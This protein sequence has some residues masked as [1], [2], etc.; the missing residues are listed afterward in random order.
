MLK[1]RF[2]RAENGETID[3][4]KPDYSHIKDSP[5]LNPTSSMSNK[6]E[7][8]SETTQ[9]KILRELKEASKPDDK[10]PNNVI[11][12]LGKKNSPS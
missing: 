4:G 5:P 1:P 3:N 7:P 2:E 6:K 12:P 9:E 8:R 10:V 11:K